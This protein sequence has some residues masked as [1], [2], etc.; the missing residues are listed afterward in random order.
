VAGDWNG[1][2]TTTIGV[3]D[4]TTETWY[5]KNSNTEGAP[6]YTPFQFGEPG[7]TPVVGDWNGDGKTTVGA[8]DPNGRWFLRNSND[9]GAPDFAAF[10]FGAGAVP[11]A[12]TWAVPPASFL[13]ARGQ[14]LTNPVTTGVTDEH[15]ADIVQGAIARLADAGAD[16]GLL[17]QL[18]TVKV[19]FA[20]LGNGYLG[21]VDT[22]NNRILLD[23]NAAGY[24]WFVDATP[25]KDDAFATTQARTGNLLAGPDSAAFG[26]MDLLSAVVLELTQLAGLD[27]TISGL[28]NVTLETGV[29]SLATVLHAFSSLNVV[30][31]QQQ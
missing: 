12:G 3:V 10:A 31:P 29:R 27:Q 9:A 6:D 18:S 5:L 2:G 1:D 17:A 4:P 13:A 26:R 21:I 22:P 24:G 19:E 11:V 28:H 30:P 25:D 7:W 15:L 23:D 16:P 20:H 8:V 14:D